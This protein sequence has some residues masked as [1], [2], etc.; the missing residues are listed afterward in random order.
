MDYVLLLPDNRTED[1][2]TKHSAIVGGSTADRLLNCPG[3]FQLLQRIPDQVEIPSEYAN[4]GSAMHAV[5]D[6]LMAMFTDGF[7]AIDDVIHTAEELLGEVFYDRMLE[8]HH[9]NDSIIPAIET[10][11]ELMDQ[12]DG[13]RFHVAANELKVKF[14][15]VPGAFGTS[16]LLIANKKFVIL[17]DWKFGMGVPVKAVYHEPEGD[18]VNP[19]L[20][21]YFAGAM[22]ELPSMFKNKRYAVAVIQPRTAERLTHTV[23]TGIEVD[24]FVEDVDHAIIQ[25][26]GKNPPLKLGD[27][28]RW[29]PARPFCPLHT[30]PLFELVG[31]EIMPAQLRASEVN[32]GSAALYGEFLAKAKHLADLAADYKKQ[33]DE[34]V[35]A[36][37]ENGGSVPGWKL[38]LKTKLRQ[39]VDEDV[40]NNELT[41][42][43]FG[44]D[45]IWQRK[46]QTFGVAEKAAK[47][48]KVKIP[49]HLRVAPETDE[50]VIVPESDPAPRI[51][52]AKANEEF[53]AALKQLRHEQNS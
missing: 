10:L 22:S 38:K 51:D 3:S 2:M 18:R 31:M 7:P 24:M 37:L 12:Y 42:L 14:P 46:L 39:W 36:Y 29:C 28:C 23:I 53:A 1:N 5:M 44:Q 41:R 8:D 9:L 48:L 52:R 47:R 49:D 32:D 50:T 33:V 25:A 20:L 19:Q 15:S 26:L 30:E 43:G 21:F 45:E 6:R 40:V 16:D 34:Q 11:W 13:G 17:V 35:H 27:H 4:Y